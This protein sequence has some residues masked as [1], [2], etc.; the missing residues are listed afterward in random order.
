MPEQRLN[1][2]IKE[3]AEWAGID[4]VQVIKKTAGGKKVENKAFKFNLVKSHTARR[5]F[6]TNAYLLD[7]DPIDIME[8]SG[9]KS[10]KTFMNYIKAD[11]LQK[12]LK[13]ASHP[14]FNPQLKAV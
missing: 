14:F 5:S 9:H 8:V 12:A 2:K 1:K 3:V 13:I 11:S 10:V 6:C 7:M 4:E